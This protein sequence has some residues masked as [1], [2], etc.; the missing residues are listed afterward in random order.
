M[1]E[2]LFKDIV[3]QII[4]QEVNLK[5]DSPIEK[6]FIDR[7][8]PK[9]HPEVLAASQYEIKDVAGMNFRLDFYFEFEGEKIGVECDGKEFH[10]PARDLWRDALILGYDKVDAIYR[11]NGTD[12]YPRMNEIIYL[13]YYLNRKLFP[14]HAHYELIH[15]VT[16]IFYRQQAEFS[17]EDMRIYTGNGIMLCS[18][19]TKYTRKSA[20]IFRHCK[21]FT[22]KSIEEMTQKVKNKFSL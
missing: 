12:I 15:T 13:I 10:N 9:M 11:F 6:V 22:A 7:I 18:R 16:E 3:R 14:P 20:E 17:K 1:G 8:A 5:T 4:N 2:H 19:R 21:G